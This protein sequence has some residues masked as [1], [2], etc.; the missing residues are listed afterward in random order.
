MDVR[1]AIDLFR[2]GTIVVTLGLVAF[3]LWISDGV[4]LGRIIAAMVLFVGTAQFLILSRLARR[5]RPAAQTGSSNPDLESPS[6]S[7]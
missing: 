4:I 1:S 5:K 6:D 7:Q 2:Y 3:C